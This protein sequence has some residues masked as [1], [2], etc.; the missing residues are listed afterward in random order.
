MA[1]LLFAG[2]CLLYSQAPKGDAV[3]SVKPLAK[4]S[5]AKASPGVSAAK[6]SRAERE[7]QLRTRVREFYALIRDGKMLAALA[8]VVPD[9]RD[10]FLAGDKPLVESVEIPALE[11]LEGDSQVKASVVG[12]ATMFVAGQKVPSRSVFDSYWR[13]ERGTWMYFDPPVRVRRTPFG[14]VKVDREG[15]PVGGNTV[16]LKAKVADA[17][18]TLPQGKDFVVEARDVSLSS[19]KPGSADFVVTNGSRGYLTVL[20]GGADLA[21]LQFEPASAS[22]APGQKLTLRLS[23]TPGA[24]P[25]FGQDWGAIVVQPWNRRTEFRIRWSE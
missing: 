15:K 3:P 13:R 19:L 21:G 8:F 18:S 1:C 10:L 16:D 12:Q 9:S 17:L 7:A 6:P 11:W 22:V 4:S 23:W 25:D 24:K 5:A 14:V 20:F 2:G